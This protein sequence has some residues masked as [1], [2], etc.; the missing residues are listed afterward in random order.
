VLSGG[1][2]LADEL[3]PQARGSRIEVD[4][5]VLVCKR[6]TEVGRPARETV[7][8]G[9]PFELVGVATD[10][11][12]IGHDAPAVGKLNAALCA[13][14]ANRAHQVLVGAHPAGHSVHDDA[15]T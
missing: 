13:N 5:V 7:G 2:R 10:E 11:D 9:E 14:R 8:L 3:R 12:G 6:R 4:G 15:K 1:N